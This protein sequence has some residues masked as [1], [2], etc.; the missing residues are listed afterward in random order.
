MLEAVGEIGIILMLG[1]VAFQL[2]MIMI[3][4]FSD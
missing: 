2:F 4:T 3:N 1:F